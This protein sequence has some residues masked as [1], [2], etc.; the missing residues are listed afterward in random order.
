MRVDIK[1]YS[2]KY[3][4]WGYLKSNLIE[5]SRLRYNPT[6]QSSV[7]YENRYYYLEQWVS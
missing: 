6:R 5:N 2:T 1:I 7:V 3:N 4:A